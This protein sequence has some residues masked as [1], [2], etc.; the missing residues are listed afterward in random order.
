MSGGL[1]SDNCESQHQRAA[2]AAISPNRQ[3]LCLPTPST[4][5]SSQVGEALNHLDFTWVILLKYNTRHPDS[6]RQPLAPRPSVH[7]SAVQEPRF[8]F[9]RFGKRLVKK[10]HQV[11]GCLGKIRIHTQDVQDAAEAATGLAGQ[12]GARVCPEGGSQRSFIVFPCFFR[13]LFLKKALLFCFFFFSSCLPH[14]P[15]VGT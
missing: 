2:G 1:V 7:P 5:P 10:K 14:S 3:L 11:A 13:F 9:Q 8:P 15:A 12:L 6:E 4:A